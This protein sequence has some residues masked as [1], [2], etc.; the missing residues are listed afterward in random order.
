M[1]ALAEDV[2]REGSLTAVDQVVELAQPCTA[3]ALV[4]IVGTFDA[5]LVFE[6]NV[7]QGTSPTWVA[8][9]AQNVN[10]GASVASATAAGIYRVDVSGAREFRVRCSVYVSGTAVVDINGSVAPASTAM[11]AGASGGGA[12]DTELPPAAALADGTANPTVPNVGAHLLVYDS[13]AGTWARAR[14]VSGIPDGAAL[15][16]G[17]PAPAYVYNGAT[18]DRMRT[19]S[20]DA[21]AATGMMA[22]AI[23]G[24]NG[25]TW[26]RL[27]AD[28]QKSLRIVAAGYTTIIDATLTRPANTTAYASG[29]EVTDTGGAVRTLTSIARYSGGSGIIQGVSISFSSNW[30]TKPSLEL[31]IF[32]TTTAPATDNAAYDVD[33]TEINTLISV[34]SMGL[35]YIGDATANTGNFAMDTGQIS[36][37]FKTSGS[38]NLFMRVVIRNAGQAGANSDTLKFRFRVLQD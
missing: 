31:W 3:V 21:M 23:M 10:T 37:P 38:A 13:G 17:L 2:Y 32:D 27:Q 29:D 36:V 7:D 9:N 5:T 20:G 26:D 15:G 28:A 34:I 30:A 11:T 16:T 6:V 35:T 12:V 14:T 18:W 19:A 33:D 8:T 22:S 24:W 4:Q 25:T 1:G